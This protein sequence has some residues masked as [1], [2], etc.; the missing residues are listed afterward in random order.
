M[1]PRYSVVA[2]RAAHRCEYCHAPECIFNFPFEVEHFVPENHQGPDAEFNWLWP[3]VRG[4][5]IHRASIC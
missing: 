2:P 1:N 5:N 4:M 3:V